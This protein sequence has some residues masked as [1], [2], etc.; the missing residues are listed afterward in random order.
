[1]V[2]NLLSLSAKKKNVEM[3][4]HFL[5]PVPKNLRTDPVR[6]KQILTNILGNALKFTDEGSVDLSLQFVEKPTPELIVRVKDTGRG[7]SELERQKLFKPFSQ[8]DASMSRKYGGTGL[9]LNFSREL[10]R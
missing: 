6:F 7:I 4:V 1:E 5:T 2:L 8:A 10:V 3:P 9:G